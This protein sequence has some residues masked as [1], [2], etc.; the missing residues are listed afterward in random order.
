MTKEKS[1]QKQKT[2][3]YEPFS[4]YST[5]YFLPVTTK[6]HLNVTIMNLILGQ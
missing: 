4:K 1:K 6:T 2:I 5:D 3:I